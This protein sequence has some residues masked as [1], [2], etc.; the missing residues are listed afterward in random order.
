MHGEFLR[1]LFLQV[2]QE[3][4]EYFTTVS[5]GTPAQLDQDKFHFRSAASTVLLF[6]EQSRP[7]RHESSR[8]GCEHEH[9]EL[10]DSLARSA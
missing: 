5:H 10:P 9:E 6:E 2:H 8:S 1:L 3:A 7:H 4:E